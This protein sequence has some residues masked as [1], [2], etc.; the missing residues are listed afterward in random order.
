[1][2]VRINTQQASRSLSQPHMPQACQLEGISDIALAGRVMYLTSG[3]NEGMKEGS[4]PRRIA[5]SRQRR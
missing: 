1:M 5:K 2:A 3:E 4:Q